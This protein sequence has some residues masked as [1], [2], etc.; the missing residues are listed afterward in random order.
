[1]SISEA[2]SIRNKIKEN[3]HYSICFNGNDLKKFE[4]QNDKLIR[5]R[6]C[7]DNISSYQNLIIDTFYQNENKEKE[8]SNQDELIEEDLKVIKKE[9]EYNLTIEEKKRNNEIKDL[10]KNFENLKLKNENDIK[11][12][13]EEIFNL[14]NENKELNIKKEEEIELLKEIKLIE[15]KNEY[16]L[17][18]IKYQN[19]KELEKAE[20]EKNEEIRKKQFE[21]EKEI[22][23]N[24]M[25]NKAE[26]VQKIISMCKNMDLN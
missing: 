2:E 10:K 19:M 13:N 22:K 26:L 7:Y 18:L 21:A 3:Y 24:E 12:K 4:N 16:K 9:N 1:M 20:F 17:N 15:L 11:I 14:E 6:N 5:I 23:F 25:K 8:L